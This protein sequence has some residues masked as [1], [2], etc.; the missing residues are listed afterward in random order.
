MA[1]TDLTWQSKRILMWNSMKKYVLFSNKSNSLSLFFFE[2]ILQSFYRILHSFAQNT[3]LPH[4]F[5]WNCGF[6]VENIRQWHL[7]ENC[8]ICGT[9]P[10]RCG[11]LLGLLLSIVCKNLARTFKAAVSIIWSCYSKGI[12]LLVK[13][14]KRLSRLHIYLTG[15]WCFVSVNNWRRWRST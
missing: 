6:H 7:C 8:E 13:L 2:K 3:C 12:L 14:L 5:V 15:L 11:Q 10:C 9:L 4:D 1:I